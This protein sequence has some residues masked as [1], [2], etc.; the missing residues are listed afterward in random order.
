M[1]YPD[2][3][4]VLPWFAASGSRWSDPPLIVCVLLPAHGCGARVLSC[5]IKMPCIC[6]ISILFRIQVIREV[7]PHAGVALYSTVRQPALAV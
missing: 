1:G 4:L 2:T 7:F 6:M 3:C 5:K